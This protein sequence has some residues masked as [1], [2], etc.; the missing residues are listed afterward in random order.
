MRMR[1]GGV[2]LTRNCAHHKRNCGF[3]WGNR[4][5]GNRCTR[6]PANHN[7]VTITKALDRLATDGHTFD[8][9][10][11]SSVTP[12][13]TEH[14]NRFGRYTLK[15]ERIPEP[16]DDVRVLRMP[17]RSEGIEQAAKAAV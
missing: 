6:R 9:D 13:R 5:P 8:E 1:V 15:R 3:N 4:N 17:P 14:I 11:V 2:A 12:Y 10:L 16:Q 7:I